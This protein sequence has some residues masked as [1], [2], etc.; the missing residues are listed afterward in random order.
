MIA[1]DPRPQSIRWLLLAAMVA[2]G[3]NLSAVKALTASFD[4]M[5]L[6]SIRMVVAVLALTALFPL[7]GRALPTFTARQIAS[8]PC[9]VP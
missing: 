9:G 2:W 4:V 6:A 3:V 8:S 1:Q 7:R 5:T